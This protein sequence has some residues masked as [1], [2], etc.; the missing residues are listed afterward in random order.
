MAARSC[1][2]SS[3]TTA[4]RARRPAASF[5]AASPSRTS[6]ASA[7]GKDGAYSEPSAV[8][9]PMKLQVLIPAA[10]LVL[11]AF[12]SAHAMSPVPYLGPNPSAQSDSEPNRLTG[13]NPRRN[14][15]GPGAGFNPYL[16]L[17]PN[18]LQPPPD[19]NERGPGFL[20]ADPFDPNSVVNSFDRS[21]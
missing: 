14:P 10:V 8:G 6:S 17:A 1:P 18:D 16:S 12:S 19:K 4:A 15:G 20:N 9:V 3:R 21:L 11:S 7:V 2:M 13:S 5:R